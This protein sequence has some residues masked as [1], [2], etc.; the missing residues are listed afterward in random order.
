MANALGYIN[1]TENGF[2]GALTL[3]SLNAPI[4]IVKNA[5][6]TEKRHPDYRVLAGQNGSDIGA[7]WVRKAK[8]SGRDYISLTLADPLIGPRRVYCTI[9]PVKGEEGRHVILWNPRG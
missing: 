7:G 4:R 9:A 2:T 6:K 3:M 5:D 8:S 1:E